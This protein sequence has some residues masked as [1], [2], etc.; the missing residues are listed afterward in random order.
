MAKPFLQ[1]WFQAAALHGVPA[2]GIESLATACGLS[3]QCVEKNVARAGLKSENFLNAAAAAGKKDDTRQS[4]K[5]QQDAGLVRATEEK[6]VGEGFQRYTLAA[7]RHVPRTKIVDCGDARAFGHDRRHPKAQRGGEPSFG[8]M[9]DRVAGAA[10]ALR[11]VQRETGP[12]GN[13]AGGS[14]EGLTE[15]PMKQAD[16]LRIDRF[17]L[18]GSYDPA[19][20]FAAIGLMKS[21]R[22]PNFEIEAHS[23][24]LEQRCIHTVRAGAGCQTDDP[25]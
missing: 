20:Q 6:E 10:D 19:A 15:K 23:L 16:L 7:R 11:F 22:Q 3:D 13:L 9:A 4:A 8:I 21:L 17:G 1:H 5:M 2:A 14:G 25:A 18:G 12:V 24:D